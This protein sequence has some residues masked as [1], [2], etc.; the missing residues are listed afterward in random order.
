M[1]I[2]KSSREGSM[3]WRA[4]SGLGTNNP[5][6]T[7]GSCTAWVQLLDKPCGLPKEGVQV[8][9]EEPPRTMIHNES[10]TF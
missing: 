6:S 8:A 4:V 3:E 9:T 7:D 1:S 2:F 5:G 10:F